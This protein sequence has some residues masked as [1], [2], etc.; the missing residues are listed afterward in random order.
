MGLFAVFPLK[1]A[2]SLA[3][4]GIN[5]HDIFLNTQLLITYSGIH[6]IKIDRS[7]YT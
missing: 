4:S 1:W 3:F 7:K 2:C 6:I 5:L